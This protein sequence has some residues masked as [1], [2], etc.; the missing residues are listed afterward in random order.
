MNK[1][2][3]IDA[4]SS[5]HTVNHHTLHQIKDFFQKN[6]FFLGLFLL[7]VDDI[8]AQ[9]LIHFIFILVILVQ[10]PRDVTAFHHTSPV[11][12]PGTL[13]V[14]EASLSPTAVKMA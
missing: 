7:S 11:E 12:V 3:V 2:P 5:S 13:P 6:I 9:C 8:F 1:A 10:S 4:P 14:V